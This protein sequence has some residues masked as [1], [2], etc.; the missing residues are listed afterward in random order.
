MPDGALLQLR[1]MFRHGSLERHVLGFF[2]APHLEEF[3]NNPEIYLEDAVYADVVARNIVPCPL[4]F[5]YDPREGVHKPVEHPKSHL[6][7]GQYANCRIPVSSP[8]TPFWFAV[9]ILRNFYHTAFTQDAEG[10]P[11]FSEVFDE[12]I[13]AA[14]RKIMFLQVPKKAT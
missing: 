11:N 6:T 12:S 1:Y 5:D 4:R 8:L 9:F 14:E 13:D 7:V 10:L 2:P 3:Q